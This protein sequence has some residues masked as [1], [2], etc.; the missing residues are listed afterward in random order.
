MNNPAPLKAARFFSGDLRAVSPEMITGGA[1]LGIHAAI[2][3]H[4]AHTDVGL[5]DFHLLQEP[6]P[7]GTPVEEYFYASGNSAAI[8]CPAGVMD[9]RLKKGARLCSDLTSGSRCF[10]GSY[11]YENAEGGRFLVFNCDGEASL[12]G[13]RLELIREYERWLAGK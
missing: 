1:A 10:V 9:I 2:A 13:L 4:C 12:A 7:E 8:P 3:L 6:L 11:L 5:A